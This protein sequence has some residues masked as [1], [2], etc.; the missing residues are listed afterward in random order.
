MGVGG[1]IVR[2]GWVDN[3]IVLAPPSW[4]AG[5]YGRVRIRNIPA[6]GAAGVSSI[7]DQWVDLP[8]PTQSLYATQQNRFED[9]QDLYSLPATPRPTELDTSSTSRSRSPRR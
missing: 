5:H 4:R 1:S 6:P 7:G 9:I 3:G 8:T 2:G